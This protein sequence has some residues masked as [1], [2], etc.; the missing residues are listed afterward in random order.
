MEKSKFFRG[1]TSLHTI[2]SFVFITRFLGFSYHISENEIHGCTWDIK[3]DHTH[4]HTYA[5]RKQIA[6]KEDE[7]SKYYDEN[8]DV[9][10]K[11]RVENNHNNLKLNWERLQNYSNLN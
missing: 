2:S 5:H 8:W 4:S 11:Y 6:F 3:F 1:P 10:E 7:L 9:R